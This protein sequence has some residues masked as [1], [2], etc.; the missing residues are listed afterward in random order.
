[1]KLSPAMHQFDDFPDFP[2]FAPLF[3]VFFTLI[4]SLWFNTLIGVFYHDVR[5]LNK[6]VRNFKLLLA[7]WVQI[8]I[9]VLKRRVDFEML[10]LPVRNFENNGTD[11][12]KFG[13]MRNIKGV[14]L[15]FFCLV[16]FNVEVFRLILPLNHCF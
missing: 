2:L 6:F 16:F 4:F 5:K 11:V 15:R 8:D 14:A 1:M 7:D 3:L 13:G 12:N 9:A 10:F